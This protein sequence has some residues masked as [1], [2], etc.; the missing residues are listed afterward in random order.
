[1]TGAERKHG[2]RTEAL[3]MF[4]ERLALGARGLK[5]SPYCIGMTADRRTVCAAYDAGINFFFLSA[6]LHWPLYEELRQGLA[7]LLSRGGGVRDDV[8]IAVASYCTQPDFW[9][10]PFLDVL[11]AMPVLEKIDVTVA[12]GAYAVDFS[13]RAQEYPKHTAGAFPWARAIGASFHERAT[14]LLAVNHRIVDLAFVRSNAMHPGA[15]SDL[16]PHLDDPAPLVYNFKS[17]DGFVPREELP[18]LGLVEDGWEPEIV[19][20]YRYALT[21]AEL[22]GVLC[23]LASPAEVEA[24]ANA[25]ARGPLS[26]D[27]RTYLQTLARRRARALLA[28]DAAAR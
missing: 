10:S 13:G 14:A 9:F 11:E 21:R 12:G 16:F 15:E 7:M 17:T 20:H 5:V 8:V 2:L 19:D 25:L 18:G 4:G 24:L 23:G 22:D 6:D 27:E 3:P 1:V 26:A 28:P